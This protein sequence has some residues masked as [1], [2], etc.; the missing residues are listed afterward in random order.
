MISN[1]RLAA[2]EDTLVEITFT[3]DNAAQIFLNGK[4]LGQVN[5]WK[6]PFEFQGLDLRQGKNVI[7]IAAWD[8]ECIAAMSGEFRVP[9]GTEFG[10]I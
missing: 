5:D 2:A 3:A 4:S 10:T 6:K 8:Q 9:N 7:G 1:G